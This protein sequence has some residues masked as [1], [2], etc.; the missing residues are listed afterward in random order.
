MPKVGTIMPK[1]GTLVHLTM[2]IF[3]SD[4]GPKAASGAL[5]GFGAQANR[6]GFF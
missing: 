5:I 2:T 3:H 1:L 4:V 6:G